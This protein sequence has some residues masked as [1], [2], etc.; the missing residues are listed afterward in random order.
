MKVKELIDE[1]KDYPEDTEV[2][3]LDI[4]WDE[5]MDIIAVINSDDYESVAVQNSDDYENVVVIAA[6]S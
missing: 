1:L 3:V 5:N 4:A 2:I 6:K